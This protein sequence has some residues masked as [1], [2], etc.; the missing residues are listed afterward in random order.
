MKIKTPGV[1]I[2]AL[3]GYAMIRL[4]YERKRKRKRTFLIENEKS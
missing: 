1:K 4:L 3:A 2:I